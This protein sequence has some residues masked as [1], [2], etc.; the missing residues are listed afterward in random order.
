MIEDLE[1]I[2]Q[3][4]AQGYA[5]RLRQRL[6]AQALGAVAWVLVAAGLV[7]ALLA[8]GVHLARLWG[9]VPV[10]LGAGAGLA[11]VG[12][13]LGLVVQSQDR[14]RRRLEEALAAERALM[15]KTLSSVLL[16]LGGKAGLALAAILG[17]AVGATR[18]AEPKDPGDSAGKDRP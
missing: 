16:P 6:R 5:D 10:L 11:L 1:R 17:L 2:A 14:A 18:P 3:A 13:L 9:T 7:L 15:L 8:L 12:I 4:M